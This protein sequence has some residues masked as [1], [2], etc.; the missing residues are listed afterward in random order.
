MENIQLTGAVQI[1][2]VNK[3]NV[4]FKMLVT[5]ALRGKGVRR[6][7]MEEMGSRVNWR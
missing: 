1:M 5:L 2:H 6:M 7:G 3:H 4:N